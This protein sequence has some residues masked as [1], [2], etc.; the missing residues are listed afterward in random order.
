[1][2]GKTV[3]QGACL[4]PGRAEG[5]ITLLSE[6]LSLWGGFDPESGRVSDVNHP[7]HGAMISGRIL[8]MPGGRGSS[9]SSSVLLESVRLGVH[10]LAIL[11]AELDPILVV[12][13][14]VAADLYGVEIPVVRVAEQDWASLQTA[15]ELIIVSEPENTVVTCLRN[16]SI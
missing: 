4:L 10:P 6:P 9:S 7:Q 3:I 11:I 5:A 8:V 14:L 16:H 1:M 13:A 15:T 12:G 2:K